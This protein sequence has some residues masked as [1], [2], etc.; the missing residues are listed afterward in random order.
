MILLKE[1][2][3]HEFSQM[4]IMRYNLVERKISLAQWS[5]L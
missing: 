5:K 1:Y 2:K 3:I 4:S